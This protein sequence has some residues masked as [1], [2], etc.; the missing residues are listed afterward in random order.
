MTAHIGDELRRDWEE[1]GMTVPRDWPNNAAEARDRAAEY[2]VSALRELRP[3]I[4]GM[5]ITE[6]DQM[7]RVGLAVSYLAEITRMMEA[8]GAK[9]NPLDDYWMAR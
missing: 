6:A 3:I 4:A 1:Y 7:R 9:T 5:R 2:S 8:V